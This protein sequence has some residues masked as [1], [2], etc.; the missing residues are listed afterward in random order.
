MPPRRSAQLR[1]PKRGTEFRRHHDRLALY[2]GATQH[3]EYWRSYWTPAARAT[4]MERGRLGD[5]D[6]FEEIFARYL[7]RNLPILEAGCGPAHFVAALRARGYD[8]FGVDFEP[9]VVRWVKETIPDLDVRLGDVR[10][11][12]IPTGSLGGYISLGV[13]EHFEGGPEE[14][15]REARRVLHPEG[16]A[17]VSTPFLNPLRARQLS[18]PLRKGEEPGTHEFHQYYFSEDQLASAL[19][20]AGF[21]VVD[22]L[23]YAVEAFL[24]REHPVFSR[25]WRSRFTRESIKRFFRRRMPFAPAAIRNRYAHMLLLVARPIASERGR[26]PGA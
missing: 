16:V 11:L 1:A 14:A 15:L 5:L 3:E 7:P 26:P 21:H 8:A 6:E 24:I 20:D 22:R 10:S 4:L 18:A 9:E 19:T 12:D 2:H 17:F 25:F 13:V 23:P